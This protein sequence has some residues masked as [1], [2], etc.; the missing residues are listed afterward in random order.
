M[1]DYY[2]CL[3]LLI[4]RAI[5]LTMSPPL[6]FDAF[7]GGWIWEVSWVNRSCWLR[8]I[9]VVDDGGGM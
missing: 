2:I 4:V 9:P 7:N 1:N 6:L 3:D 5:S 8:G